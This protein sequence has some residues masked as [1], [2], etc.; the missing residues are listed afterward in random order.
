MAQKQLNLFLSASIPLEAKDKKYYETAD[1]I[2]IRDSIL[3]LASIALP[4]FKLIWGGHPSI[5]PL[6]ANVLEHSGLNIQDSV[7]LYQSLYFERFFPLENDSVAH[8]IKTGDLGDKDVSLNEMREKMIG[9]NNFYA[10][11]FIGG[12]DGVEVEYDMFKR[13]HPTAKVYPIASTGAAAKIIYDRDFDGQESRL[14]T[15]LS[16]SSLFKELLEL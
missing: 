15:C 14:C 5:T 13:F 2:A 12:M 11:I 4:K 7:T 9:D 16:Y 3:A 10:G 6:I 1:V 8:I